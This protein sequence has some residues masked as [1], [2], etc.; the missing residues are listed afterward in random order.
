M[1]DPVTAGIAARASEAKRAAGVSV[2]TL[3]RAL[4]VSERTMAR[5]LG[6]EM[7]WTSSDLVNAAPILGV[8]VAHLLGIEDSED[9]V[10]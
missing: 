9:S 8:T 4:G 6:G 5:R 1:A 7:A 2:S 3:A 10:A